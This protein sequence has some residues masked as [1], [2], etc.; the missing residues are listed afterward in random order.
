[1]VTVAVLAALC[2]DPG[3]T[4]AQLSGAIATVAAV[5]PQLLTELAGRPD[6]RPHH[7]LAAVRHAPDY[8]AGRLLELW[9]PEAALVQA[10]TAAHGASADLIVYCATHELPEL[11]V[12]LATQVHADQVSFVA[13]RWAN[14]VGDLPEEIRIALVEVVLTE[15]EPVTLAGLSDW[16]RRE[17]LQRLQL[18]R[19]KRAGVA[20]RL[21]EP[22]PELWER[23]ASA[24]KQAMLIRR[25]LLDRPAELTD[26]VLLA[27][28]PEVTYEQLG[29]DE[30]TAGIRLHQAAE[31]VRRWP[32]LREI[33]AGELA[34]VVATAIADGWTPNGRY[35]GPSWPE[36]VALAELTGEA[37]LLTEAVA[38]IRDARQSE[39]A[40]RDRE[41]AQEWSR[42]RA[43]AVGALVANPA[44]P[45]SELRTL[46]S[47][48]DEPGLLALAQTD[49]G[50]LTEACQARLDRLRQEARARQPEL[51]PVPPDEQL[52]ELADPAAE[53]GKHLRR[54]RA[55]AG[56]RDLTCA[57]VLQS[58][59]ST[60]E[61]L[62][63]LPAHRVLASAEQAA[64]AAG[65]IADACRDQEARWRTLA[66]ELS[67]LPAK[68][69]TFG[70]WLDRLAGA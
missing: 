33:A 54:L 7:R 12:P 8:L 37:A 52:A 30:F 36:L 40:P 13:T 17:A 68:G 4:D 67:R 42:Q 53:L 47:M 28:L 55:S 25:I 10:A 49:D 41:A 19:D 56:Q 70:A 1:M 18:E 5:E 60:P 66:G 45:R 9:P 62:R 22:V 48:L 6:L 58:R 2:R 34:R 26:D 20:W 64:L 11:V 61:I 35:I 59:F 14:V 46:V 21:L 24:S 57:G 65:M 63:A 50:E 23:L 31:M 51:V 29:H 44:T 38:A 15:T 43:G 69:V 3:L 32:R 27:C 39:H 16:E